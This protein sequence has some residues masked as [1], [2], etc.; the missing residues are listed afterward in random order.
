MTCFWDI[1]NKIC[2]NCDSTN[3]CAAN[4]RTSSAKCMFMLGL[5]S[6]LKS[7]AMAINFNFEFTGDATSAKSH[8][9][10]VS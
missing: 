9:N 5:S 6:S 8:V 1:K 4:G 3:V 7:G 2:P 10:Y